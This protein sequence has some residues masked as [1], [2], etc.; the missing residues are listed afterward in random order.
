MRHIEGNRA[1]QDLI[2]WEIG[3]LI[4]IL[5]PGGWR[6]SNRTVLEKM[7][8]GP[9]I[10]IPAGWKATWGWKSTLLIWEE[11]PSCGILSFFGFESAELFTSTQLLLLQLLPGCWLPFLSTMAWPQWPATV[12]RGGLV[13]ARVVRCVVG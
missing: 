5:A 2:K 9:W 10:G 6:G 4:G 8:Q 1:S 11:R 13:A 3:N 7:S 12:G